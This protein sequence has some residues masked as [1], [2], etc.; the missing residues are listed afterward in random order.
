[1]CEECATGSGVGNDQAGEKGV[2]GAGPIILLRL[3]CK[4]AIIADCLKID[5]KDRPSAWNDELEERLAG[6][7]RVH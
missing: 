3:Y 5:P 6:P 4:E 2:R 7:V 1:M